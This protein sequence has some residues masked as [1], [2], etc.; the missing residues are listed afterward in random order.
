MTAHIAPETISKPMAVLDRKSLA[1]A[2][3]LAAMTVEPRRSRANVNVPVRRLLCG[4]T[5]HR[6]EDR[7]SLCND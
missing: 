4:F 5:C 6:R 7:A 3:T 1:Y 2:V